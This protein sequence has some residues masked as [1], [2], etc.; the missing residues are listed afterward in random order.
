[1]D[2]YRVNKRRLE[3]KIALIT[4]A[5]RGQGAAEARLFAREGARV[6][7][8]DV[9][10]QDGLDLVEEINES[11]GSAQFYRLDVTDANAWAQLAGE[12]DSDHGG[13]DILVNNAGINLRQQL[14]SM[15]RED[16]DRLIEVNLTGPMLGIQ[17]CARLMR[18]R[19]GGAIVNVGSLAGLMGHPTT[20][21]S[22]AKWGLRGLTKSAAMD[23]AP[24]NIRVNAMHPG[25]VDTPI[26]DKDSPAY[27][28][29]RD[30][31]PLRRAGR[32]EELASVVLFLASDESSYITGVDLPVDGGFSEFGA[33]NEVWRRATLES[34]GKAVDVPMQSE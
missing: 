30:M 19:G 10:E 5:A 8:T 1:M 13:L 29:M 6:L 21:Y 7:V 14:S 9:L 18:Q 17:A 15:S 2:A 25:L 27:R 28:H 11:D 34:S 33:Y 24:A 22:S 12:I 32:V 26:I 31:T 16:W 3:N 23:L 20:G 4:G